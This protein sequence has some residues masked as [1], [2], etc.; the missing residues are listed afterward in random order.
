VIGHVAVIVFGGFVLV[1]LV[2]LAV[3]FMGLFA[4]AV[5]TMLG[6]EAP[7]GPRPT[8][9]MPTDEEWAQ[10]LANWAQDL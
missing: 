9:T 6:Y 10:A 1:Y 5:A 3:I 2:I 7:Q 8:E 4:G